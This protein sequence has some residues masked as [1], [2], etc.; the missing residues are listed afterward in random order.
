MNRNTFLKYTLLIIS[1]ILI[2]FFTY[3]RMCPLQYTEGFTQKE[4]FSLV[5]NGDV[6][7]EF[8][9][10]IYDKIHLPNRR[11]PFE[12][13]TVMDATQSTPSSSVFLDI[14]SGTGMALNELSVL[15]YR[16][17][18]IETSTAMIEHSQTKYPNIKVIK[19]DAENQLLFERGSFSHI[20][21]MYHTI[22]H[23]KNKRGVFLN[24]YHWLKPGGYLAV[25]L[26]EPSKYDTVVPVGKNILFGSPQRYKENRITDQLIDFND[27]KYKS[28]YE[29]NEN[30][31]HAIISETFV[32]TATDKVRQNEQTLF[33]EDKDDIVVLA[34]SCGFI[35]V[36]NYSLEPTTDDK[37]QSVYLF[38]RPRSV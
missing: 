22:Y 1:V 8:Y 26:V 29:Y 24:S 9:S 38:E 13:K 4:P 21:C 31:K 16:A 2:A 18:G 32:D 36:G 23:F 30:N 20:L 6:F 3:R 14:G 28:K 5:R 10:Q 34:L 35:A 19:G 27:F 7:D 15:G 37:H 17:V 25:H 12:L 33:M 11:V